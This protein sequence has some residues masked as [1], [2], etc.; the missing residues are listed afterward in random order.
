MK[1]GEGFDVRNSSDSALVCYSVVVDRLRGSARS[2]EEKE[3]LSRALTNMG[4]IYA[5]F[6]FDYT[7]SLELFEESLKISRENDFR[8]NLAF[9]YLNIGGVYLGCNMMYGKNIF[10]K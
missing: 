9:V 8:E 10:S 3:T 6:M 2:E 5:T 1:M 4:Y 7:R